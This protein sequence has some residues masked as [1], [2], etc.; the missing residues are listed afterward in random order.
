[1]KKSR[2]IILMGAVVMCFTILGI[3]NQIYP[4]YTEPD[5]LDGTRENIII[6]YE[7]GWEGKEVYYLFRR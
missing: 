3:K 7:N 1:M 6:E 5:Y 4:I 2:I